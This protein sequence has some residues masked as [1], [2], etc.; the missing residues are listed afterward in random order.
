MVKEETKKTLLSLD[1]IKK[2]FA[3]K[4]A[5]NEEIGE[6]DI[7]EMAEKNH[8]SE[9]EE[10]DLFNWCQQNDIFLNDEEDLF[11]DEDDD[12]SSDEEDE[13]EGDEMRG[14]NLLRKTRKLMKIMMWL[15]RTLR[16]TA[17]MVLAMPSGSICA[18]SVRFR[19]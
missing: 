15:P 18:R 9:D 11:S 17:L 4:A 5:K 12:S 16:K 3:E 7:M 14:M 1:E 13:D 6:K 19:C 2:L 10:E 8:L